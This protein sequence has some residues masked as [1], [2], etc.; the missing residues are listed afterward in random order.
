MDIVYRRCLQG[1]SRQVFA[2]LIKRKRRQREWLDDNTSGSKLFN[3]LGIP[4]EHETEGWIAPRHHASDHASE[5]RVLL[6][7]VV[8]A[9]D[10][11]IVP[12]PV[13]C[14]PAESMQELAV[15]RLVRRC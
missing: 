12:L 14:T 6:Q 13:P 9:I 7:D 8:D 3:R 15:K 10:Y 11:E 4:T 1:Q 2:R 5:M